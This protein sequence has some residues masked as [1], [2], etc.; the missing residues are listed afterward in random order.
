ML[1]CHTIYDMTVPFYFC[2]DVI[3]NKKFM[4]LLTWLLVKHVYKYFF[5]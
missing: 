2:N 4:K 1:K 3:E 5:L